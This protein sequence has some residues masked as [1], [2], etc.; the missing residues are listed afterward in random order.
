MP[1][2]GGTGKNI[3]RAVL[4]IGI[5]AASVFFGPA[6]GAALGL[7][8][9]PLAAAVGTGIISV[10]G[11]YLANAIAPIPTPDPQGQNHRDSPSYFIEGARNTFRPYAPVPIV[12]G[13]HRMVPPLGAAPYTE[14][15]GDDHYLNLLLVWGVGPIE[16][17][18]LKIGETAIDDFTDVVY[19]TQQR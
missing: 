13:T 9:G 15:V 16:V 5:I 10:G 7:G 17:T 19:E 4:T 18:D 11:A 1:E 2:G 3:L 14:V 8:S 6:L 12:L